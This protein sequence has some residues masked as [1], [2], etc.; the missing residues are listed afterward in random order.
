MLQDFKKGMNLYLTR[1]QYKNTFT[2]DLWAALEEAS[3]KPVRAVMSTWTKQMGFPVIRVTSAEQDGNNRVLTVKQEK[4]VA[5]NSE[6]ENLLCAFKF[7]AI[8]HCLVSK[9]WSFFRFV[10]FF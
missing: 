2:E 5:D 1:H 7:E 3:K 8:A 6:S 4:F 9:T 10:T